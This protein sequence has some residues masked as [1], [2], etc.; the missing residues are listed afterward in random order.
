MSMMD[1]CFSMVIEKD[2]SKLSCLPFDHY[3]SIE[4]R[5]VNLC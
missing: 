1:V 4:G 5:M 3:F 2:G